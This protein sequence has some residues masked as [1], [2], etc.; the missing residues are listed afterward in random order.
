M[1]QYENVPI[2]PST[3]PLHIDTTIFPPLTS[4]EA[5][6]EV[7]T[8]TRRASGAASQTMSVEEMHVLGVPLTEEGQEYLSALTAAEGNGKDGMEKREQEGG[9]GTAAAAAE[10]APGGRAQGQEEAE[11]PAAAGAQGAEVA[12]EGQREQEGKGDSSLHPLVQAANFLRRRFQERQGPVSFRELAEGATVCSIA[13]FSWMLHPLQRRGFIALEETEGGDYIIRPGPRYGHGFMVLEE[14]QQQRQRQHQYQQG[15]EGGAVRRRNAYRTNCS[16]CRRSKVKCDGSR[17]QCEKRM[18]LQQAVQGEAEA[19]KGKEE[20]QAQPPLEAAREQEIAA[21]GGEEQ[22][23]GWG[24]VEELLW[25]PQEDSLAF[26]Q[27]LI[28]PPPPEQLRRLGKRRGPPKRKRV[29]NA[30]SH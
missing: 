19:Q 23:Q 26:D 20:T 18:A 21:Q 15:E 17:P 3:P 11:A 4:V 10:E 16:Y 27:S 30:G 12:G 9:A 7:P 22:Q 24:N 13:K 6:P 29:P 8:G 14:A 25:M 1:Q 2:L 28:G 5:V